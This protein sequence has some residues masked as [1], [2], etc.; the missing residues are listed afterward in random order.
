MLPVE[1]MKKGDDLISAAMDVPTLQEVG[2]AIRNDARITRTAIENQ[3]GHLR[4]GMGG[5]KEKYQEKNANLE[6]IGG[7]ARGAAGAAK[8]LPKAT[9]EEIDAEMKR[10]GI[11]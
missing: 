3:I 4:T 10:R 5:T 6:P 11:K 9:K 8:P 2:R 1:A 7:K